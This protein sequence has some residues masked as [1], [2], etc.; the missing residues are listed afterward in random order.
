MQL[1]NNFIYETTYA[2]H[3]WFNNNDQYIPVKLS[4]KIY[5]NLQILQECLKQI[6]EAKIKIGH[7]YGELTDDGNYTVKPE[8]IDIANQELIDLGNI[9]Q[10]VMI[11]TISINEISDD[12]KLTPRQMKTIMFM[13]EE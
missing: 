13:I 12:I 5:K 6:E 3:S 9:T 7:E 1:S 11:Q 8:N 2:L 4:F 10:E